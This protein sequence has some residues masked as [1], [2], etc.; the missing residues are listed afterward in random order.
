MTLEIPSLVDQ[1]WCSL[2]PPQEAV[3]DVSAQPG[4]LPAGDLLW[5]EWGE[6]LSCEEGI[7]CWLMGCG[8][9]EGREPLQLLL[10]IVCEAE[11]NLCMWVPRVL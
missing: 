2:T 4:F 7:Y 5:G 11:M 6:G 3:A 1:S 9:C 8:K 10:W